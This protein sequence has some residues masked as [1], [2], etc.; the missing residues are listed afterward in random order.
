MNTTLTPS[1]LNIIARN[2]SRLSNLLT[3]ERETLPVSYLHDKALRMAYI[4][5]FVPANMYKIHKPLHELSLH[6]EGILDRKRLRIL[7]LGSGPGT[8]VLG[9][10]DFFSSH[11]KRPSLEFTAVDPIAENLRD[12]ER[13][14]KSFIEKT[15]LEASLSTFKASIEKTKSLPK[16][17]FD[18]IILSN[19]LSEVASA[20]P[21][22]IIKRTCILKTIINESLANDGSCII[23]EPALHETSRDMLMNRDSLLKEGFHAYSP[24]LM[25]EP[26]P[27]LINLR[28]WCHE[29]IPWEPPAVIREIDRLT[30]LRKDSLKFSYLIIRKDRLSLSDIYGNK[31][32]R[33]VS[34][35]LISKG[36]IEF[37]VCGKDGRR[38]V[39]RLD[40]DK[41]CLNESFDRLQRGDVA[42]MQNLIDEGKRLKIGENTIVKHGG[43]E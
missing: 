32:Y 18:I 23:I 29:D 13:L 25:N 12:A 28:D 41:T 19:L 26:C 6:P 20:D 43:K 35:P 40:K 22:K 21:Q 1:E 11:E 31:S 8:A 30:G 5:Y 14:F 15:Y 2:V 9:V 7:D 27:A 42:S 34:E 39:V 16:G 38:L 37:Y 36:K 3:R 17:P 24:C 10:L 4:L 33:V